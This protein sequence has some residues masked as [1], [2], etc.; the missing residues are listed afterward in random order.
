MFS[1]IFIE[2]VPTYNYTP[3]QKPYCL[4][5]LDSRSFSLLL[6]ITRHKTKVEKDGE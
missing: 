5:H 2:V 3:N 6:T 4:T 1:E